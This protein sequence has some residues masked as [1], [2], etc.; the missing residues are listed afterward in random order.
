LIKFQEM[1]SRNNSQ[2]TQIR[3]PRTSPW[4]SNQN[5]K[6]DL[7]NSFRRDLLGGIIS[8]AKQQV[9]GI[10]PPRSG[11]LEPDKPISIFPPERKE[12]FQFQKVE[13]RWRRECPTPVVEDSREIVYKINLVLEEIKKLA[14][15]TEGLEK[16]LAI[17]A[18][19]EVPE[20]PGVYHVHFFQWILEL[21]K[22]ARKK[23][24][25][26]S[27]WLVVWQTKKRKKGLL[28]GYGFG[29][30]KK[31]TTAGVQLMLGNEMGVSR[32]GT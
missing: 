9:L 26:A 21:I 18:L 20:K 29:V 6:S 17:Q 1:T 28:A 14:K 31:S 30:S 15:E 11:V 8:E 25:E 24:H 12:E 32:S 2:K 16:D 27:T 13:R 22:L 3:A 23:I 19:E 7:V 10:T 4:E 5:L